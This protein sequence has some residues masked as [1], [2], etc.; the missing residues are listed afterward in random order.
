MARAC[1][2]K[3]PALRKPSFGA[4][5]YSLFAQRRMVIIR[6]MLVMEF[7]IDTR[8]RRS[9]EALVRLGRRLWAEADLHRCIRPI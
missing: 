6:E 7:G 9:P 3:I 5:T 1:N 4:A 8:P 2:T